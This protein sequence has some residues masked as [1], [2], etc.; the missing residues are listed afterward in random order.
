MSALERIFCFLPEDQAQVDAVREAM[1][2]PSPRRLGRLDQWGLTS[3]YEMFP[4]IAE[5]QELTIPMGDGTEIDAALCTPRN[6]APGQKCPVIIMPAP[7]NCAGW[8][9]YI[10]MFLRWAMGGYISL[11]YSQRGLA[12]STGKVD[13]AGPL[14]MSDGKEIIDWLLRERPAADPG[15][16]GC[17]GASYGAG[18]SFLLAAHDQ[19]VKAASGASAWT[20]LFLSLYENN[21]RHIQAV[22]ALVALFKYEH[23]SEEFQEIIEKVRDKHFGEDSKDVEAVQEFAR[24]RSPST[25]LETYKANGLPM[26]MATSWHETIFSVPGVVDFYRRLQAPKS[27]LIQIGDHGNS[28]LPGLLGLPAK[29]TAMTYRW[30]DH[31]LGGHSGDGLPPRLGVRS[32]YMHNL[33]SDQFHDSWDSYCLPATEFYLS[34]AVA[35]KTDGRMIPKEPQPGW[36][37][38]LRA[39]ADTEA[40]VAPELVKTGVQEREGRPH[41][42]DT[43]KIDREH[44]WVW[45]SD[46]LQKAMRVQGELRM[47]I[48]VKAQAKTAT[49]VA[50]LFDYDPLLKK[51][52]IITNAPYT[53]LNNQPGATQT[54]T[55]NLQPAH[56]VLL[57][58]HQLQLIIDTIDRFFADATEKDTTL[59]ASSPPGS[60]SYISIP[61]HELPKD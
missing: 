34:G 30:M 16:I 36:T 10:G 61:L 52:A 48:T 13:V 33:F 4:E 32:E 31:Y 1:L 39:G 44:A 57:P 3:E 27:L 59:E 24:P 26:L 25:Y 2:D 41:I 50:Y 9:A 20:D 18:T 11:G 14:D 15:Q 56:Y 38:S 42:Y 29:P 51:A 46:P 35:G 47:Q 23:C 43:P 8:A 54:V 5:Y 28:E 22:E 37:R 7:L 17:F 21:T 19:R 55:F 40:I 6:L 12:E 60:P 58:G 53:F 45:N 49:I